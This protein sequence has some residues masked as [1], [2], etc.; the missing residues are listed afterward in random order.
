MFAQLHIVL[1]ISAQENTCFLARLTRH[2]NKGLSK[3]V[4]RTTAL[5]YLCFFTQRKKYMHAVKG[6]SDE[7]R[8]G[9]KI[10]IKRVHISLHTLSQ[11]D[12]N[13]TDNDILVKMKLFM[14]LTLRKSGWIGVGRGVLGVLGRGWW[15]RYEERVV[16]SGG[17]VG[18]AVGVGVGGGLF[19]HTPSPGRPHPAPCAGCLHCSR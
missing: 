11:K 16:A 4:E 7:I 14:R 5:L 18:G 6:L 12:M 19:T 13:T 15:I 10:K 3:N 2:T 9:I 1:M 8:G 17:W